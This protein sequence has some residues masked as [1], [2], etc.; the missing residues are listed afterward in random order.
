MLLPSRMAVM[1]Y[2]SQVEMASVGEVMDHLKADYGSEK[3]FN[4]PMYLDHLMA[5]EAN[6]FSELVKY[7]LDESDNL[8]LF[9][10]ITDDGNQ[11][12]E[13]YVPQKY[14]VS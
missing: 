9:Y 8:V 3:Q 4:Y 6:G 7:E 10:K 14:R 5:L 12:V 1:N 11:A 2:L 13:K